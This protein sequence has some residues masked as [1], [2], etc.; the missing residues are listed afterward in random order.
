MRDSALS[1][2]SGPFRAKHALIQAGG[3]VGKGGGRMYYIYPPRI[4]P[5]FSFSIV[6]R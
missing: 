4:F 2:D 5:H 1:N 6:E 3:G